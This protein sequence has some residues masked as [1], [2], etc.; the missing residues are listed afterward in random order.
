LLR[1]EKIEFPAEIN[2]IIGASPTQIAC[3]HLLPERR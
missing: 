2:Q 3:D 1:W